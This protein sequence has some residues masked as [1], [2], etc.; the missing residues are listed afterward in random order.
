M[1]T[2]HWPS[3]GRTSRHLLRRGRTLRT[4]GSGRQGSRH[5]TDTAGPHLCASSGAPKPQRQDVEGVSGAGGGGQFRFHRMNRSGG[6]SHDI[7]TP[8]GADFTLKDAYVFFLTPTA[9]F[10]RRTS[11][12]STLGLNVLGA[13]SGTSSSAGRRA[14]VGVTASAAPFPVR[15]GRCDVRRGRAVTPLPRL[16]GH[17]GKH[18]CL[19][20]LVS[21]S[22]KQ[23]RCVRAPC[24][25]SRSWSNHAGVP[26]KAFGQTAAPAS[27]RIRTRLRNCC[28][29]QDR[30]VSGLF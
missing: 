27:R 14:Q 1:Q 7:V 13:P 21:K 23:T 24:A 15:G 25:P 26:G 2:T 22:A 12:P 17:C 20:F 4:R 30:R 3:Q 6:G 5:G 8:T 18:V 16:R 28:V 11:V 29:W 9:V 10:F 19:V